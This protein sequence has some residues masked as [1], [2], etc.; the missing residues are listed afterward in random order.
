MKAVLLTLLVF[1]GTAALANEAG[2][3]SANRTAFH[4]TLS[5]QSVQQEYLAARRDGTLPITS[6]AASVGVTSVPVNEAARLDAR[7]EA[8]QAAR[9]RPVH[10]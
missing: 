5:R 9:Q 4:S 10:D 6:D 3:E 7:R 1:T 8:R 2:D